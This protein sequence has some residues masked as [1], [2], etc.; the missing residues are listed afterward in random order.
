MSDKKINIFG[1]SFLDLLCGALA[2]VIILFVVVPKGV[3]E[4][5]ELIKEIE[6]LKAVTSDLKTAI[7]ELKNS[8][9]KEIF[10]KIKEE[11]E[12]VNKKVSELT[13]VVEKLEQQIKR[14]ESENANL[15]TK[16]KQQD[17]EIKQL[18]QRLAELEQQVKTEK[19]KNSTANTIEKTLGV[20]AKFGVLCKWN[21]KET[22]VD[23]GVQRFGYEPEQCWR[24]FPNKKWGILGEDIRE[25]VDDDSGERFELFYVPQ[26]Y[27]DEYTVWVNVYKGSSGSQASVTCIMVFHPGKSDE[28]KEELGPFV[29]RK[30]ERNTLVVSFRLS[31]SGYQIIPNIEPHW[32]IGEVI[33]N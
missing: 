25:R 21:E 4:D 19:S 16:V 12:A 31:E 3:P 23:M 22:D 5:P 2:A 27:P 29:V 11:I 7:E 26:I 13:A 9:P 8:V 32:G 33:K 10:E 20:F 28:R 18:R 30:G 17:E 24:N 6:E 14:M 15:R 1:T